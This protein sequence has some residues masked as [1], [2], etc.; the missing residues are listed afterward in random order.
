MYKAV[1]KDTVIA[2]SDKTIEIEQNQYFPP[3]SVKWEYLRPSLTTSV[4]PWKGLAHYY[5]VIREDD[6][7]KDAAWTY[8]EPKDAAKQIKDHV[9]FWQDVTVTEE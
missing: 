6:I 3:G 2:E 1:W 7:S 9:A 4:C 5:D 8:P